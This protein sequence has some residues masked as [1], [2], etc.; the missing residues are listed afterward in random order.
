MSAFAHTKLEEGEVVVIGPVTFSST[1]SL[2]FSAGGTQ[3]AQVSQTSERRIGITNQRVIIEQ[4]SKAGETQIISNA[5]VKRV[6]VR[7]ERLGVKIEKIETKRG[8]TVKLNIAGLSPQDEARLFEVFAGAEIGERRGLLGGF[9]KIGPR[10]AALPRTPTSPRPSTRKGTPAVARPTPPAARWSS[11]GRSHVDD[12]DIR[13][14]EDLR[15]YYPLPEEY[16]YEETTERGYVVKRLSDGAQFPFLLEEEL[17][18]FD[19]PVQDP[20]RKKVTV[21]VF[22]KK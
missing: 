11:S 8:Q 3:S 10:P 19:V 18:G 4:G 6:Y 16:D 2:S 14:L 22:K 20:K 9:S 1:G 21:E 13:T 7:R 12:A 17:L 15:R 5:D